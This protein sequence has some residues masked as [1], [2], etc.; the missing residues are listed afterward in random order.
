MPHVIL[1]DWQLTLEQL[2]E[3]HNWQV[4]SNSQFFIIK[5]IYHNPQNQR[6]LLFTISKD[7][8]YM[9]KFYIA[10]EHQIERWIVKLD[11]TTLPY[12]TPAVK[13]AVFEVGN[14]LKTIMGNG[15]A[16]QPEE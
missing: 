15:S 11:D 16:T 2:K 12:R 13:M 8:T 14:R 10:I 7:Y 9:Q 1:P 5:E 6:F 4:S 3:L